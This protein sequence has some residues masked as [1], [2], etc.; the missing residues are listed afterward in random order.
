MDLKIKQ[1]DLAFVI[2]GAKPKELSLFLKVTSI[3]YIAYTYPI[4]T[5]PYC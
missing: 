2:V 5:F 4:F 3:N 1:Y